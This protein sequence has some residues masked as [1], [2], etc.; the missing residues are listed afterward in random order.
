MSVEPSYAGR[1]GPPYLHV[2]ELRGRAP[3][4]LGVDEI[5]ADV[6]AQLAGEGEAGQ[7]RPVARAGDRDQVRLCLSGG[8]TPGG[9][10]VALP[11]AHAQLALV[12]GSWVV[13]GSLPLACG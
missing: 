6:R 12:G 7:E 13:G 3:D 1:G 4:E 10:R 8:G 2:G 5:R 11:S 9:A